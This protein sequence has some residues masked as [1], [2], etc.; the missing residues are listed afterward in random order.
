[1]LKRNSIYDIIIIGGYLFDGIKNYFKDGKDF[2]VNITYIE[3][4]EPLGTGGGLYYVKSMV[5]SDFIVILGDLLFDI[6]IVKFYDFHVEK[7]ALASILVHPNDHPCDSDLIQ[8]DEAYRI[9]GF[10]S[11]SEKINSDF[12]NQVCAGIYML[13]PDVLRGIVKDT[14]LDLEHD[15][16]FSSVLKNKLLYAYT[17]TEY[18][19]DLGTPKRLKRGEA[20]INNQIPF[21]RNLSNKQKAVFLDRDGTIIKYKP[22]L[23]SPD[24]VVLED[25]VIDAIKLI[26]NS[27]Y[28]TFV[29]T[30]Q[31]VVARNLC[32]LED[33][34]AV[35]RRIETWLGKEGAYLNGFTFCPHHP[36]QGYPGENILYKK[37]CSCRKPQIGLINK[38]AMLYH[39]DLNQSWFIGDSTI[40]VKTGINAGMRTILLKTGVAGQDNKYHV[41]PDFICENLLSAVEH[42]VPAEKNSEVSRNN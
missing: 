40:D 39:I 16:L 29:I 18:V 5:D 8:A 42:V 13:A 26:N 32:S 12:S 25:K 10:I 11:K 7:H 36:D 3:E 38:L 20:D 41:K 22:L 30:N 37:K 19:K 23:V 21:K 9:T 14:K 24:E 1:M 31:P 33:V 28:L 35:H 34:Y 15:L 6:N 17:T 2:G 4:K 27:E